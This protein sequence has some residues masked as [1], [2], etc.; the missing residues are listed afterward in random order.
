MTF[1]VE[2]QNRNDARLSLNANGL[3]CWVDQNSSRHWLFRDLNFEAEPGELVVVRGESGVG[4]TTLLSILGLLAPPTSGDVIVQGQSTV[5]LGQRD[6]TK[7]R[8][9]SFSYLI[10]DGGLIDTMSVMASVAF[11]LW[12]RNQ[13][14]NDVKHRVLQ[15]L[16][17]VGLEGRCSEKVSVL[18]GG[19]KQRV[20]LARVLALQ[21]PIIICDE[22]TS[23]L[24]PST[25][26]LIIEQL[27]KLAE[28]GSIV[29]AASHD[30]VLCRSADWSV[31]LSTYRTV[32]QSSLTN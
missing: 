6:L 15:A 3:G 13:T 24:D 31:D 12:Y 17:C 18:S 26:N 5:K 4:K 27:R 21:T 22:P 19:E 29:I 25:S 32:D 14:K 28:N 10:Q 11:P 16:A 20:G 2:S 30:E 1:Q 23:S 9:R 7:I 8:R